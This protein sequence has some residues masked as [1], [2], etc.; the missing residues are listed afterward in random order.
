MSQIFL[1]VVLALLLFP[2]VMAKVEAVPPTKANM[3]TEP[4]E[5]AQQPARRQPPQPRGEMLYSNHC[6]GCHE[7]M[8]HIREKR[9]VQHL[10][11]LRDTVTRW[12]QEL[13]LNWSSEEI[14]DVVLYLNIRY[15][16]YTE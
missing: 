11:A 7:S 6:L 16:H 4:S 5:H 9:R 13:N 10:E 12:S 15:Y 1:T 2:N 3:A 8:I 14:E